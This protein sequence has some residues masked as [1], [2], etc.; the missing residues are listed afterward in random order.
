MIDPDAMRADY[1]DIKNTSI[2]KDPGPSAIQQWVG[3]NH[4]YHTTLSENVNFCVDTPTV[5]RSS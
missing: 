2:K 5:H 4:F 1:E 3:S